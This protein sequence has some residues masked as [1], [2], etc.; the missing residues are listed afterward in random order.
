MPPLVEDVHRNYVSVLDISAQ[1]GVTERTVRT[2]LQRGILP[3][4]RFGT[5]CVLFP[6]AEYEAFRTQRRAQLR[7]LTSA[8]EE[9]ARHHPK[10]SLFDPHHESERHGT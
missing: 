3:T 8:R 9:R 4:V 7:R 6:R 1:E 5:R 2:W 10:R